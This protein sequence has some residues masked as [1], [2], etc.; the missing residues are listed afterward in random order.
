MMGAI[1]GEAQLVNLMHCRYMDA[2]RDMVSMLGAHPDHIEI[3]NKL[4]TINVEYYQTKWEQR[5]NPQK[6]LKLDTDGNILCT[7]KYMDA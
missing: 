7:D 4:S 3:A 1:R 5:P 2:L 6:I